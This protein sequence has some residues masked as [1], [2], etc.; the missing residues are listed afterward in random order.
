MQDESRCAPISRDK[1]SGV[2]PVSPK[3]T[4]GGV[5]QKNITLFLMINRTVTADSTG[6]L[7]Y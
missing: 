1:T 5:S 2:P 7:L 3:E 4:S 6:N